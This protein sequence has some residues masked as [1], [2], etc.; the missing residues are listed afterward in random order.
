MTGPVSRMAPSR[1]PLPHLSDEDLAAMPLPILACPDC[2]HAGVRSRRLSDGGIPGVAETT[3][4]V[5]CPRC[6]FQGIPLEFISADDYR[7]F[8]EEAAA[9]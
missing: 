3:D 4:R 9:G 1:P 2:G 5:A 7:D 8:L 6:G